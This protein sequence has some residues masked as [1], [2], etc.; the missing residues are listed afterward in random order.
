MHSYYEQWKFRHPYPEDVQAAFEAST[1][2]RLGWFFQGMMQNTDRYDADL[3]ALAVYSDTVKVLVR[4]TATTP[5]A[6]PVSTVDKDGKILQTLWTKPFGNTDDEAELEAESQLNFRRTGVAALVVDA[7]Y[8][9]PQ[10]N[11]R[12]D[13]LTLADHPS[14]REPLGL[15]PLLSVERWER[16]FVNFVPVAGA[17]HVRQIHAGGGVLQQPA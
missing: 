2:Q 13:R 8:L 5:W 17:Q 9:T 4:T 15:R 7:A 12:N 11:R 10:L 3:R 1:G 14:R 6:V 16:A